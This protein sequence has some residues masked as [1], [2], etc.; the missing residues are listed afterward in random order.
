MECGL[1][2]CDTTYQLISEEKHSLEAELAVAEVEQVFKGGTEQVE[3]HGVV[4]T[5]C[6]VPANKR[7][8]DATGKGLVD[9][10]LVLELGMLGLD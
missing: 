2:R 7:D 3:D 6:A 4:V 5:F 1:T 8:A 9:L 10:G